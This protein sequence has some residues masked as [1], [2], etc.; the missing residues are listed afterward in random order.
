VP[1]RFVF[2][3]ILVAV[4]G[5]VP[6][7]HGSRPLLTGFLDPS[8]SATQRPDLMLSADDAMARSSAA[9]AS[10]VRIQLYWNRVATAQPAS[11]ADPDDPAYDW[12]AIDDQVDAAIAHGLRPV[13]DFRSAPL[14]AQGPGANA[15]GTV[16]PD[17]GALGEFARAAAVRY[18][19]RVRWWEI[20]NEPNTSNFLRPQ[21]DADGRSVAPRLYRELVNAAADAL[22]DVDPNNVVV[23]GETAPRGGRTGHAPLAFLRKM[24]AAPVEADVFTHHPYTPGSPELHAVRANDVYLAD[25]H[26]WA[27]V[28]RA[29]VR[30]GRVVSHDGTPKKR[31]ALWVSELSWDS[32]APDPRGVP[33]RLLARWTAEAVYRSWQAGAR[34]V[35]WGQLRDYPLNGDRPWGIYQSGLFRYDD[36]PKLTLSAFRFPFVAYARGGRL[37]V[38][39]RTP[40]GTAGSVVIERKDGN[41]WRRV[42]RVEPRPT[43]IFS[44]RWVS[45]AT[46]G[47]YRARVGLL[48]SVPFSLVRP[49]ERRVSPFGCGGAVAC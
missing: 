47:L 7:A 46:S 16:S 31:V 19:G 22:H 42:R 30:A 13:L 24:L 9:G 44:A 35:L 15:A 27:R 36:A 29:A 38:W 2:P 34:V 43:G 41:G 49:P 37:V 3:T 33:T 6:V 20:W 17:P 10:L 4:L 23:A 18:Q 12:A 21:R 39:G 28:V 26:D 40:P 1:S 45:G 25:L 32:N 48:K 14:W 5:L 8:G 11:P